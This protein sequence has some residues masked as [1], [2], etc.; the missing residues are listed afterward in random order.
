MKL[1]RNL[2]VAVSLASVASI[3]VA[4]DTKTPNCDIKGK[5]SHVKDEKAC[6]AKKGTWITADAAATTAAPAAAAAAP[7]A[8]P[9]AHK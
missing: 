7:A 9:A 5:K 8:A 2:L 3:A 6:T 4:A 1:V